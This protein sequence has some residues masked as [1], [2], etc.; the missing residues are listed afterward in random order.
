MK[1]SKIDNVQQLTTSDQGFQIAEKGSKSIATAIEESTRMSGISNGREALKTNIEHFAK[2]VER[3]KCKHY[4]WLII[5][6]VYLPK[7]Y[8]LLAS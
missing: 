4:Q 1:F 3:E 2:A 7:N 6:F 5:E 8:R